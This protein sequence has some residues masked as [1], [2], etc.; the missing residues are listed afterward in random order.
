MT[1]VIVTCEC[2]NKVNVPLRRELGTE[3]L[4]VEVVECSACGVKLLVGGHYVVQG[5]IEGYLRPSKEAK[6]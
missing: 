5:Y 1:N 4:N 3:S 2:G 6:E